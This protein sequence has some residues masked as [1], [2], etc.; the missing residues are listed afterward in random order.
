M[1]I[2]LTRWIKPVSLVPYFGM[3]SVKSLY[4]YMLNGHTV[5][6]CIYIWKLK[7]PIKIKIFMWV[8]RKK[9]S[10][11]KAHIRVAC[12]DL[13]FGMSFMELQRWYCFSTKNKIVIFCVLFI[14]LLID[15]QMILPSCERETG[16]YGFWMRCLGYLRLGGGLVDTKMLRHPIL[17]IF[18]WL[19]FGTCFVILEM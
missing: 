11:T 13:R 5:F 17:F 18:H 16:T 4:A 7:V 10:L 14:R 8:L 6:L 15:P 12:C 3:F 2:T 9:V 19:F 1:S